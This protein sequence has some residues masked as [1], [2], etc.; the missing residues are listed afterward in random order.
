[1]TNYN[2]FIIAATNLAKRLHADQKDKAGVSYFDGH[3]KAVANQGRTW[4]EKIAG[5]LHDTYEDTPHTIEE[6]LNMLEQEA[7]TELPSLPKQELT[8]ALY[9]LNHNNFASRDEYI[10]GIGK[11]LLA[12]A[13]K[14]NDLQNNMDLSRIPTPTEKDLERIKRYKSEYDYLTQKYSELRKP[15]ILFVHGYNSSSLGFTAN[16]LRR[17]L[18]EEAVVF[19]PSFSNK[20]EQFDN[21]LANIEQAQAV[22]DYEGI[23]LVIGSSMGA[24]TAL[25]V[26]GVP[27]II[28]NPCMKP[29][30]QFERLLFNE[31]TTEEIAK[32]VDLE[33]NLTPTELEQEQTWALFAD[34]DELF[35]YKAEFQSLFGATNCLQ[36]PGEHRNNSQRVREHII[37]L[38]ETLFENGVIKCK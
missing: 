4:L 11:Q 20:L 17:Q 24:F 35:S 34:E 31:T 3:L 19:A 12:T 8:E 10:V 22:V 15:R 14:L 36:V 25:R 27:R 6:V 5:Y 7:G 32:Y 38:I 26:K 16:E 37:P 28:I 1:M 21:I 2:I 23:D 18:G 29:S 13:V 9:L 30:E 33:Q